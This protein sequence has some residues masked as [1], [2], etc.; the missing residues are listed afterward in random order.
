M[1]LQVILGLAADVQQ[2]RALALDAAF[3]AAFRTTLVSGHPDRA[4]LAETLT[5]PSEKYCAELV[6]VVDPAAIHSARQFVIRTLAARF[7]NDFLTVRADNRSERPYSPDD[8]RSG[9][10][11]LANLCLVYLL[12]NGGQSDIELCLLQYRQADNMTDSIG[13]LI[14]LA[15][16]DCPERKEVLGDFYRRWQG[17]RLVVDKWFSLQATSTLPGAVDEIQLLLS[18]PDFELTNP[19]RFRSLVAAFSQNN[20]VRFHDPSGAGYRFLADQLLRL[21]PVN[22]QVSARL[23]GPLTAWRRYEEGRSGLMRQQLQRI[24]AAPDLPR[25]VYE[26]VTK[27]LE[28]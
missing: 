22:P 16:C 2:G 7:R 4:F 1:A 28:G 5:L 23:L 21:I 18:H 27:S 24:Q 9:A 14:P 15:S 12:S 17:D 20:Q 10:R 6:Q 19:N 13:A 8:G 26:V 3:A 25:D 11:R